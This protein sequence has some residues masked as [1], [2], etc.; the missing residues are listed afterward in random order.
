MKRGG[1]KKHFTAHTLVA[2]AFLG[3][4]PE[5][6]ECRHLNGDPADNR[7]ANLA[8][9]TSSQNGHDVTAHGRS[10]RRI[11]HCPSGHE[12]TPENIQWYQGRRYCRPCNRIRTRERQRH[13]RA[14]RKA[15]R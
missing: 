7:L 13:V 11:T 9:G 8:W 4:R 6:M 5:R 10:N 1:R 2:T 15:S 12:Y 3:L 14:L